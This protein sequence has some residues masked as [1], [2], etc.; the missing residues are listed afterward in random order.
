MA[1]YKCVVCSTPFVAYRR[2]AKFCGEFCRR[3]KERAVRKNKSP[4][5]EAPASV[6]PL[7]P[8]HLFLELLEE[9]KSG[10]LEQPVP[11]AVQ[12]GFSEL[13][14]EANITWVPDA[15][16]QGVYMLFN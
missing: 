10:A 13:A 1:A 2:N 3:K 14:E 11:V 6:V 9:A 7:L 8:L 15:T 12:P 16:R 4:L 5:T